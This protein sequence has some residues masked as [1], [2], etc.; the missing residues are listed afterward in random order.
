MSLY[1]LCIF[2]ESFLLKVTYDLHVDTSNQVQCVKIEILRI[3]A[4][5]G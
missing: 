5:Q 3:L 1:I 2:L 4:T